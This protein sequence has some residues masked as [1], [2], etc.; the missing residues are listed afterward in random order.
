M[1]SGTVN[2]VAN[3]SGVATFANLVVNA[4]AAGLRLR[5]QATF[6]GGNETGTSD[7]FDVGFIDDARDGHDHQLLGDL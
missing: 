2:A 5:A 4:P 7:P 1:L 6:P 3:V